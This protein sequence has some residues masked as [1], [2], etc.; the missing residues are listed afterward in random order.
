MY[1]SGQG[2]A[3]NSYNHAAVDTDYEVKPWLDSQLETLIAQDLKAK[4]ADV[5]LVR[6]CLSVEAGYEAIEDV[7]HLD[8]PPRLKI[9]KVQSLA[10]ATAVPARVAR[11]AECCRLLPTSILFSVGEAPWEALIRSR[12]A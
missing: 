11:S 7:K 5:F 1:G 4:G 6:W 2:S 12:L 3:V 8:S 9:K 10:Y